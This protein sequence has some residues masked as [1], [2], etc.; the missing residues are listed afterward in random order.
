MATTARI[1]LWEGK[2]PITTRN[3]LESKNMKRFYETHLASIEQEKE[4]DQPGKKL[5]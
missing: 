5:A 3:Y 4:D 2:I 1:F